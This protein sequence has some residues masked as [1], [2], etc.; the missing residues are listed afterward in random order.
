MAGCS[1]VKKARYVWLIVC[2]INHSL[3]VFP[4]FKKSEVENSSLSVLTVADA[5]I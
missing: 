4:W 2:I 5:D 3:Y 1:C